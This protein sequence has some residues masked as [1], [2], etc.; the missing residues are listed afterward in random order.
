MKVR[1]TQIIDYWVGIPLCA[2]VSVWAFLVRLV[3]RPA[4]R[5]ARRILFIE[6]SEMGSAILAHS[7]L[8]KAKQIA[9]GGEL[10]FL[11]FETNVES[12]ALLGIIPRQ[13]ILTTRDDSLAALLASTVVAL[14]RIRRLGIDT[15]ID[16]EL[17][18]RFTAL[19]TYFSG[20]RTRVGFY[21]YTSEGL[22]RGNFLTH[23]VAYN[24]HQHMALNFMS[25]VLALEAPAGERPLLKRNV[26]AAMLP[27]P[28]CES[29]ES[30]KRQTWSLLERKGHDLTRDTPL[31]VFNPNPGRALPIRGWPL[32]NYGTL[33]KQIV[34]CIPAARIVIMGLPGT[35]AFARP[36]IDTVGARHC[37]DITGKTASLK[38]VVT[39]FHLAQVLVTADGG[40]AHMASLTDIRCVVLFGPETPLLYAPL[41]SNVTA[42]YADFA[43]SPC[44]AASNHRRTLCRD[45]KCL[46]AIQVGQ[47]LD[48][49]LNG[50]RATGARSRIAE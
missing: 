50:V 43:C 20:A 39:L 30:E 29:S 14:R 5:P 32:A 27:P 3:F 34:E 49:V 42:M 45:N 12:V 2:L 33:A 10:Y 44:L 28:R 38:E 1:F 18:S 17:F 8:V 21:N 22:F 15:A 11:I 47:V 37:I 40:P 46:Q 7:S 23:Q 4:P 13:N 41:G 9:T 36:I 26:R 48:A 31:I 24:H 16:L 19:L 25:L 6:L 35:E